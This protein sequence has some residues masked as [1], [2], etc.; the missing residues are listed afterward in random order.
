MKYV[1]LECALVILNYID[2]YDIKVNRIYRRKK[3]IVVISTFKL[4]FLK[5]VKY[6][7]FNI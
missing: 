4:S 1:F 3:T 6:P 5:K 7:Q 2:I